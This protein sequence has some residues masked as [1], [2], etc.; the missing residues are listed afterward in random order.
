[1]DPVLAPGAVRHSIDWD[2]PFK[3]QHLSPF[4]EGIAMSKQKKWMGALLLLLGSVVGAYCIRTATHPA[5]N[6]A[7]GAMRTALPQKVMQT[8]GVLPIPVI[9]YAD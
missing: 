8:P 7:T 2:Q 4:E 9:D 5:S 3:I 1:L 6:V